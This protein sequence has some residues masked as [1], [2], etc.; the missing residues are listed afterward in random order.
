MPTKSNPERLVTQTLL[1][2]SQPQIPQ[3]QVSDELLLTICESVDVIACE[4][5]GYLAKLLR[6]VRKFRRYTQSCIDRY[7]EDTEVHN[8]LS[9]QTGEV[10]RLLCQTI[11]EFLQKEALLDPDGQL[12]LRQLY[13]RAEQASLKSL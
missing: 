9:D 2:I 4:C 3:P 10:E 1:Q 12:N 8:W 11:V 13:D 7:P 6:E 5:P